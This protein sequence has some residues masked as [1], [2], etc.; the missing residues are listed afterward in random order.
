MVI[1]GKKVLTRGF[2]RIMLLSNNK[3]AEW[4]EGCVLGKLGNDE[5]PY[6]AYTKEGLQQFMYAKIAPGY[7]R[8]PCKFELTVTR[9]KISYPWKEMEIVGDFFV[10]PKTKY[11][12]MELYRTKMSLNSSFVAFKRTN[13]HAKKIEM[14]IEETETGLIVKRIK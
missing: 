7:D 5:F 14:D 13:K 10:I 6:M 4:K 8:P 2:P 1:N 12:S 3:S 9:T 11:I